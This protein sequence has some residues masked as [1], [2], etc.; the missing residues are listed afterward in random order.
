MTLSARTNLPVL[1]VALALYSLGCGKEALYEGGEEPRLSSVQFGLNP[2]PNQTETVL[3]YEYD[4]S[5]RPTAEYL[6]TTR[7]SGYNLRDNAPGNISG[8]SVTEFRYEGNDLVASEGKRWQNIGTGCLASDESCYVVVRRT[9]YSDFADGLPARLVET[10]GEGR[11]T[12]QCTLV[13]N[14]AGLLSVERC[15]GAPDQ[16]GADSLIST[17]QR[18]YDAR[19]NVGQLAIRNGSIPLPQTNIITTHHP[20]LRNPYALT[21]LPQYANPVSRNIATEING[22]LRT[23]TLVTDGVLVRADVFD[24]KVSTIYRYE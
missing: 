19:G 3:R 23:G 17:T 16:A 20:T 22:Q 10:D 9:A 4:A 15:A 12:R 5:G 8:L 2:G 24:D 7:Y 14:D 1:A 21:G 18:F 6:S 11:V 13:Y